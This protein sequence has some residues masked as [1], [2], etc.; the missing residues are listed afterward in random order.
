MCV[1]GLSDV[2]VSLSEVRAGERQRQRRVPPAAADRT[3]QPAGALPE[4]GGRQR[5]RARPAQ[6]SADH[7]ARTTSPAPTCQRRLQTLVL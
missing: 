6:V 7:T 2:R 4:D 5:L 3:Q 1:S